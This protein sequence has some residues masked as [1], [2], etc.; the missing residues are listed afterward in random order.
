MPNGPGADQIDSGAHA[1]LQEICP[2][3]DVI[4]YLRSASR[5]RSL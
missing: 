2:E 3:D 5:R 1:R 4:A